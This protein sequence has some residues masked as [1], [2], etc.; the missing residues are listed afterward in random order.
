M[1][2]GRVAH[3]LG[4]VAGSLSEAHERGLVHRD[5]KPANILLG[6]RGGDPD[7][8]K[9]LDFGLVRTIRAEAN[10]T[11]PG[12][13]M[14]TPLFMSPEA[15][16]APDRVDARSDLYSLGALGYYL[17]TGRYLFEAESAI[18]VC[19][20]HMHTPPPP[21]STVVGGMD[22]DLEK[23]VMACLAKRPDDRPASAR[24]I[25][26]ALAHCPSLAEWTPARAKL[27]WDDHQGILHPEDASET[28]TTAVFPANPPR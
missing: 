11:H 17:V 12:I 19:A 21:L 15:I 5:I 28:T 7:V 6:P 16:K 13:M 4:M 27:W 24:A 25:R 26:E 8:A 10:V 22:P 1:S 3:V 23:V 9:V 14:G 18:E 20:M 2:Q